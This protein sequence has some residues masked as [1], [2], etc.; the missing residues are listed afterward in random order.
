MNPHELARAV[1]RLAMVGERDP[2][3]LHDEALERLLPATAWREASFERDRARLPL[4]SAAQRANSSGFTVL[5]L[6][7]GRSKAAHCLVPDVRRHSL[8]TL[9]P[10]PFFKHFRQC[11]QVLGNHT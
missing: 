5:L 11:S 7:L 8:P 4:P 9:V 3:R 10:L 2:I 6:I 1:L